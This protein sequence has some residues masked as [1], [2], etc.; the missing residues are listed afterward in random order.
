MKESRCPTMLQYSISDICLMAYSFILTRIFYPHATLIRRPISIRGKRGLRYEKGF[1]TGRNCRIETFGNG[2]IILGKNCRIGDNV[3]LAALN[4]VQLGDD[5]LLASKVY[6][7]DISHGSYGKG[8]SCSAP[9][10][11]PNDRELFARPISI[12]GNCWI[13][14]N[15]VILGGSEIGQGCVIGANAVVNGPIPDNCI[16]CGVPA[17]P[18]KR[19]DETTKRWVRL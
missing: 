3:H 18:I 19:Y 10:Q 8:P 15:A 14:E 6:I 7:S 9:S 16:A 1:T 4:K 12:G 2:Q 5:C 17:R 11:P 13:G